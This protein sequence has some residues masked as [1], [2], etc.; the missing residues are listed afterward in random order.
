MLV[1]I[2]AAWSYLDIQPNSYATVT[3]QIGAVRR[4]LHQLL[5]LKKNG[6]DVL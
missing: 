2:S 1:N 4:G 3:G 6:L 5:V